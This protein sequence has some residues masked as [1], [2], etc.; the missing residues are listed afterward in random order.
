MLAVARARLGPDADLQEAWAERLPHGDG[1]FD[2][3][4]CCNVFHYIHQPAAALGEMRRVLRPGGRLVLTDWC[5]DFLACKVC[6]LYLRAFDPA[7]LRTYG[8]AALAR[9]LT[10]ANFAEVQIERYKINWL[11][12]LMTAQAR[13]ADGSV[14]QP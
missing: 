2:V 6:D 8:R 9:L 1:V 7:H 14:R 3:V 10:G 11:W 4:A 12:G 5:D 13:K